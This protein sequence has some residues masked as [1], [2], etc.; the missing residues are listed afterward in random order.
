MSHSTTATNLKNKN[1]VTEAVK[2]PASLKVTRQTKL[3]EGLIS[4]MEKLLMAW[5]EYQTQK[6]ICP[7]TMTITTKAKNFFA[8][9]KEKAGPDYDVEFTASSGLFKRFKDR[10]SLHNV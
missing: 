4:D 5:I 1:K 3:Q 8:M 9:L 6:P 2:G 7:S 10:Y